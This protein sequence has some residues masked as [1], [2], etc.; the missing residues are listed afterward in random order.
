MSTTPEPQVDLN[1]L[2]RTRQ[3]INRLVQEI[4]DLSTM[5]LSPSEYYSEFLQRVLSA[6]KAPAGSIW[7][8]T[9]QGHLHQQ[10]QINM[11]ELGLDRSESD[12]QMHDE[13]LRTSIQSGRPAMVPP[14]SSTG[15]PEE[16]KT[17]PGNPTDFVILMAPIM[18]DRQ[19]AGLIEVLQQAEHNPVAQQGFL[20]FLVGMSQ[21]ASSYTRNHQLRQMTG[22]QA[23]WTQLE[24]FARQ[25]HS[26]LNPTEVSYQVANEGRRLIECD[27]LTV[28]QRLGRK[29]KVEAVSGSDVVEKR[30][31]LVRLMATLCTTVLN[32]GEKLVYQGVQD[33]SLPP[34]VLD[35]LDAYLAESNSKLLVVLPLQDDREEDSTKPRRSVL[36][37]ECFD[38]SS[39]PDQLV[40]RLD[41]IGKHAASALYNASEH[42]RIPMRFI[43]GPLAKLQDGLGGK[44]RAI[45]TAVSVLVVALVLAMIFVPYPLKMEGKGQLLPKERR[46]VYSPSQ[47]QIK[48]F[49][50]EPNQTVHQDDPLARMYDQELAFKLSQLKGDIE[51]T[52]ARLDFLNQQAGNSSLREIERK[53]YRTQAETERKTLGLK[54]EQLRN[55]MEQN[56]AEPHS[57]GLFTIKAPCSGTVL[58][59]TF[60]EDLTYRFV[61]PDQPILRIG[62]KS[63]KWEIQMKIPEKH[64]AQVLRAFADDPDKL[65][66]VDLILRSAPTKTYRG[67]L[68]RRDVGGEAEPNRDENNE[69]DPSVPAWVQIDRDDI[70]PNYQLPNTDDA[71]VAGTEVLAKIRCGPRAMGYSLFYGVWEFIYEKVVFFF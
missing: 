70:D 18:V 55:Y 68:A 28:A 54:S 21:H 57:N 10:C 27:R 29:A 3:H 39:T 36:L 66:D 15:A 32:W 26:S 24:V 49:L 34:N 59:S 1:L 2:E 12:R 31:N 25:I 47:A 58:S 45:I 43:W 63:G 4:A 23:L 11:R 13:L 50:V 52:K 30:S 61:K 19:V 6:V 20:Q 67:K 60:K 14:H 44:T 65:L 40:A 53:S 48:Q 33:D 69:T 22:Q 64:I 41:V 9:P 16:G 38:P 51:A 46:Y 35:A 17:V 8:R 37:M 5:E 7:I 62:E 71:R 42:K 56:N